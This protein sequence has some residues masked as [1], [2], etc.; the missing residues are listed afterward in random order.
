[1]QKIFF[2][3]GLAMSRLPL[4]ALLLSLFATSVFAQSPNAAG[5][6]DT[7]LNSP[8]GTF[9][10]QIILKQDAD[11][12][13]GVIKSERGE[14]PIEGTQ[15]GKDVKLKYTIKFQENDLPIT[16]T[17][18]IDGTTMKGSA[19]Y[20]G[21][22]QGDFSAKRAG[23][24]S[25][26]ATPA[27]SAPASS[28]AN[29]TGAWV[30]QVETPQGTGSPTFTFKQEGETLT[31]QYKGAFGEAPLTGTVKGDKVEFSLKVEAQGQSLSLKYTGTIEKDG[32]MKGTAELGEI[33]TAT[34]TAKRQ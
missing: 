33:G 7:T 16:L 18:A 21:M 4:L 6:W 3:G 1:L 15:T 29:I 8:Q 12:L 24:G 32:T 26:T 34:W 11:K 28:A 23:E 25:T 31:G 5:T 20:G 27:A 22:A 10:F 2:S 30:F 9:N 14:I 17:G 19:D 13:T